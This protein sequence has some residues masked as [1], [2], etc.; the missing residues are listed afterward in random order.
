MER[1]FRR[2]RRLLGVLN[3]LQNRDQKNWPHWA[4]LWILTLPIF[5]NTLE[6]TQKAHTIFRSNKDRIFVI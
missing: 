6:I 2:P 4:D 5:W 3:G 1:M